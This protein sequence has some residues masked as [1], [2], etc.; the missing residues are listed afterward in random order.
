[1]LRECHRLILIG[2]LIQLSD[3]LSGDHTDKGG[4]AVARQWHERSGGVCDTS[5]WL[6]QIKDDKS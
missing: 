3:Y 5:G 2:K 6:K 4:Q 1:M